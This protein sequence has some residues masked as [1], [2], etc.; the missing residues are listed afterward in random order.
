MS[1][2]HI[3][4]IRF[5]KIRC[6]RRS[7]ATAGVAKVGG[8]LIITCLD[9]GLSED[10]VRDLAVDG[11]LGEAEETEKDISA[12]RIRQLVSFTKKQ[13]YDSVS[14]EEML[15]KL[16]N[17]WTGS[18]RL[19]DEES[20]SILHIWSVLRPYMPPKDAKHSIVLRLPIVVISNVVQRVSGYQGFSR[21]I[22]PVISPAKIHSFSVDAAAI[23][24]LMGSTTVDENFTI[25]DQNNVS[26]SSAKWARA[27]KKVTFA[28]FLN[29]RKIEEECAKNGLIFQDRLVYKPDDSVDLIGELNPQVT[30]AI[31]FYDRRRKM[32]A[33]SR[34]QRTSKSLTISQKVLVGNM[35]ARI[36]ELS[37]TLKMS[38]VNL[39]NK[40]AEIQDMKA[41]RKGLLAGQERQ[42]LFLQLKGKKIKEIAHRAKCLISRSS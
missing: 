13:L 33:G 15:P 29:V 22:C 42:Q 8:P 27:N 37:N 28:A 20:N 4:T 19:T 26:I 5:P 25:V 2:P 39:K 21:S 9:L 32:K 36:N 7:F 41:R 10:V 17:E 6:K 3:L 1:C 11:Q 35:N 14:V 23:F 38:A 24:E 16:E 18:H 31:S 34:Q 40:R 12:V 30:P